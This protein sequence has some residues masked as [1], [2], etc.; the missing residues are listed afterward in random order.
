M[1]TKYRDARSPAVKTFLD[2]LVAL[3]K[4]HNLALSHE[5][6]HGAFQV[7]AGMDSFTEEWLLDAA[8]C[9]EPY[10]ASK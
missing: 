8:D 4:K 7:Y 2:E 5:D 10:G 6:G 9:T 3:C 1:S